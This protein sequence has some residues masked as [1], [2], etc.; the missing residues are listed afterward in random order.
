MVFGYKPMLVKV[1]CYLEVGPRPGNDFVNMYLQLPNGEW[2]FLRYVGKDLGIISSDT[3]INDYIA[4]LKIDRKM[5]KQGKE[6]IYEYMP[7]TVSLKDN[8]ISRM[9]DYK[10]RNP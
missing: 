1:D 2:L 7:A 3:R 5:L 9:M 10:D 6:K 8:F 4:G